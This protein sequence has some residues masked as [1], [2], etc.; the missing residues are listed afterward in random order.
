MKKLIYAIA[1]I[2]L[3]LSIFAKD[4]MVSNA[5]DLN[6]IEI[7]TQYM[8]D[9]DTKDHLP[10]ILGKYNPAFSSGSGFW[11]AY[12]N[13]TPIAYDATSGMT[14]I[15]D[16]PYGLKED[17]DEIMTGFIRI[18]YT[19]DGTNFTQM[20]VFEEQGTICVNPS[21]AVLNPNGSSNPAEM[22][23]LIT[24]RV[25]KWDGQQY[26]YNGGFY[27]FITPDGVENFE[28]DGPGTGY[29]WSIMNTVSYQG[30]DEGYAYNTS[31]LSNA[32]GY[33]YGA[34]GF[35]GVYF[36]SDNAFD[37]TS[38]DIPSQWSTSKFRSS[39]GGLGSSYNGPMD[40]DVDEAGNVYVAVNNMFIENQDARVPGV[41]KSTDLGQ[42]WSD[43]DQM[44][45]SLLT[46]LIDELGQDPNAEGVA[47]P[48]SMP[49]SANGFVVTGEDEFSM[50]Y[51]I[52]VWETDPDDPENQIGTPHLVEAY[53]KAGAW[54]VREITTYRYRDPYVIQNQGSGDV[55]FDSLISNNRAHEVQLA[56]TADGEG[57]IVK[58]MQE[59]FDEE[60]EK[61]VI[62][63]P[64]KKGLGGWDGDFFP[65]TMWTSDIH[66]AFRAHGDNAWGPAINIT[67]DNQFNKLS[68]IPKVV[69]NAIAAPV[70]TY[71]TREYQATST[72]DRKDYD[73]HIMQMIIDGGQDAYLGM[74][75]FKTV[76]VEVNT[77]AFNFSLKDAVPNPVVNNITEIG[78]VLDRD[79][80]VQMD[81]YN[82]VG[83]RVQSLLNSHQFEGVHV[84]NVNTENLSSGVYYYTLTVEGQSVTK[85]FV[86]NR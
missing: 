76:G 37:F 77:Q 32:D 39:D 81:L 72:S 80:N 4:M 24:T 22:N 62:L 71:M 74:W 50:A 43:F 18:H 9:I 68:W 10:T 52:I 41:S 69:P 79:A 48:G 64:N 28:I 46:T 84:V 57:I 59:E 15:A 86:V 5:P 13:S 49:Y 16:S 14:F 42:T 3:P 7:K 34:Y 66:G 85:M 82:A 40:I 38:L 51:R 75:N 55:L 21:I 12:F 23:Y 56:K 27:L 60:T 6:N 26:G 58:W 70:L 20:D 44:P 25:Y 67:D 11:G 45:S 2:V 54:G 61:Y 83:Q 8:K 78:F 17:D 33:Q 35:S 73:P 1:L 47:I 63:D 36:D 30:E 31:T 19:A 53:K 65:D 29:M